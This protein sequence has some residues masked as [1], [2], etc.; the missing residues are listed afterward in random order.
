MLFIKNIN[1]CEPCFLD[2]TIHRFRT[3]FLKVKTLANPRVLLAVSG[4]ASSRCLLELFAEFVKKDPSQPQRKYQFP[5]VMVCHVDQ[6]CVLGND[7]LEGKVKD[8]VTTYEIP[9][10]KMCLFDLFGG[11]ETVE[12]ERMDL[13]KKAIMSAKTLSTQEDLLTLYTNEALLKCAKLNGCNTIMTGENATLLAIKTLSNT[14]KGQGIRLPGDLALS[15]TIEE[16][17]L[18]N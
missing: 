13:S 7:E 18:V 15:N 14:A 11:P 1:Y 5:F 6:S 10:V 16:S 17:M 2:A 8:L 9:Y 12:S 4:G 3:H